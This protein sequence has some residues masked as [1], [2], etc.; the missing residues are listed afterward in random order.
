MLLRVDPSLSVALHEQIAGGIREAIAAGDVADGER[1]PAARTLA[2][3]LNVN[4]HT[5]LRAYGDL[6]DAGLLELR[7]GRG[8][9]VRA[10][11]LARRRLTVAQLARELVAAARAHGISDREIVDLVKEAQR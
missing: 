7:R 10:G 8:A 6:R 9:V 11:D 4:V 1:L 2:T 3:S 5:V